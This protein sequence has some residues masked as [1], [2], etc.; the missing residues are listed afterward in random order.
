MSISGDPNLRTALPTSHL[1][2]LSAGQGTYQVCVLPACV[3]LLPTP[4]SH[5]HM[6]TDPARG[7]SWSWKWAS[8]HVD[9]EFLETF[10]LNHSL[11]CTALDDGEMYNGLEKKCIGFKDEKAVPF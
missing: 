8:G 11:T 6:S 10:A 7:P 5:T 2:L 3:S 4:D 1:L 9:R